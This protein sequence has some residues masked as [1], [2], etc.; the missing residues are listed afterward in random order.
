MG[1]SIGGKG[2]TR[3]NEKGRGRDSQ[4]ETR[5]AIVDILGSTGEMMV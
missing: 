3:R 1:E 5:H 4:E 2:G